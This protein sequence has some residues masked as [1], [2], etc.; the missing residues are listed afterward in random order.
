MVLLR[1]FSAE[2]KNYKYKGILQL[3]DSISELALAC[4][5]IGAKGDAGK[6]VWEA[7]W[8]TEKVIE[9][10]IAFIIENSVLPRIDQIKRQVN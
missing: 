6:A 2:K 7:I 1:A 8:H 4:Q 5:K 9:K 10:S 3:I